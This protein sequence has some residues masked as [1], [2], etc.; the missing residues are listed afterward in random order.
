MNPTNYW[1]VTWDLNT[2][3]ATWHTIHCRSIRKKGIERFQGLV[4]TELQLW[5]C[6]DRTTALSSSALISLWL[7]KV[8]AELRH[9]D[10]MF[11]PRKARTFYCSYF[12]AQLQHRSVWTYPNTIPDSNMLGC[13]LSHQHT[14]QSCHWIPRSCFVSSRCF[15]KEVPSIHLELNFN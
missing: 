14:E 4:H 9:V 3:T 7:T 5:S 1:R 6:C 8:V 12:A 15:Q 2:G 11:K 10:S 13:L